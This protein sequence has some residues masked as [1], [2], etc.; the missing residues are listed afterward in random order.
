MAWENGRP[1]HVP[2]RVREACLTRDNNQC[3]ATL[4][5]GGRCSETTHLEA[6]HIT[7]WK[8]GETTTINMVRTL[9][10]WHH[11]RETQ[12]EAAKARTAARRNTPTPTH[13]HETHPALR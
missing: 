2:Q 13:P 9:C 1:N 11:N 7:Q 8:P 6:A 5:A 10:H 3:T 4:K 12:Q